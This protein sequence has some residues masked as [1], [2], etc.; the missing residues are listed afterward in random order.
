MTNAVRGTIMNLRSDSYLTLGAV[1]PFTLFLYTLYVVCRFYIVTYRN[2]Y[3]MLYMYTRGQNFT[4]SVDA[5]F[6][7]GMSTLIVNTGK[8]SH[9]AW[10]AYYHSGMPIFTVK[11]GIRMP[12]F[13]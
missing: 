3:I 12:I 10:D 7:I 1:Q 6:H 8:I 13:T 5:H 2:S 11:M 4:V 9:F